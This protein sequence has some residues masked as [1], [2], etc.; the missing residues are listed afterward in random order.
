MT[1][2]FLEIFTLI[3]QVYML[4][5]YRMMTN[6]PPVIKKYSY[7][8][9]NIDLDEARYITM[10]NDYCK[11]YA[12]KDNNGESFR[13]TILLDGKPT[14][15]LVYTPNLDHKYVSDI[16]RYRINMVHE[17]YEYIFK[18]LKRQIIVEKESSLYKLLNNAA[19]VLT[20]KSEQVCCTTTFDYKN[21]IY[22]FDIEQMDKIEEL[23]TYD[24][25]DLFVYYALA[26][27]L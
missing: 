27:I 5:E 11:I 19:K 25:E 23:L 1:N 3:N 21:Y 4:P 8:C 6:L 22:L 18:F 12:I 15:I 26:N 2:M 10:E 7:V 16:D 24:V 14:L 17:M 20:V 13:D 9:K